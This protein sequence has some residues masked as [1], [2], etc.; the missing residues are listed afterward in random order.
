MIIDS[1]VDRIYPILTST[2]GK[3]T[4]TRWYKVKENWKPYFGNRHNLIYYANA[5]AAHFKEKEDFANASRAHYVSAIMNFS[6]G[7]NSEMLRNDQESFRTAELAKDS[8]MMTWAMIGISSAYSRLGDSLMERIT[9]ERAITLAKSQEDPAVHVSIINNQAL[10]AKKSGN[11]QEAL[12]LIKKAQAIAFDNPQIPNLDEV[13]TSNLANYYCDDK[14]Y[15]SALTVLNEGL[16]QYSGEISSRTARLN[17]T[18]HRVLNG[19]NQKERAFVYLEKAFAIADSIKQN[20]IM[21]YYYQVR[22]N[23]LKK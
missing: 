18:M 8:L 17:A 3:K 5:V 12:A 16:R 23:K 11:K 20:D 6:S 19:M 10:L 2:P 21:R 4:L 15:E 22:S 7:N 9:L 1:L 14:K 13:L